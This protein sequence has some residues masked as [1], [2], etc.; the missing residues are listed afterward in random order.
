MQELEKRLKL[1]RKKINKAAGRI[2][3]DSSEIKL[4]AV[5][6]QQPMEKIR[7]FLEKGIKIFGESRAQELREKQKEFSDCDISWHFIGHLQRNKV[8]YLVRMANCTLIHSLDSLRLA[9]EI[10][11]RARKNGRV[12]PVLVQV[13]T[14]RDEN[15]YGIMPE[16]TIDFLS[17]IKD[18]EHI[19]VRGLMTLVPYF[20]DPGEARPYFHCLADLR[21]TGREMGFELAELSMGMTS[22]FEVAIEEGSTMVRIG[23]ALFGPRDY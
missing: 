4:V 6:K 22:D 15:K 7:F 13:N 20:D 19:S 9:R 12:V 21:E 2:G 8:K 3:R 16:D 10:D 1:V 17:K 11:K 23:R 18:L 14:A 5:S